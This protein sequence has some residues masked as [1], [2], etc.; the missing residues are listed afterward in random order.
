MLRNE[1]VD[2]ADIGNLPRADVSVEI[3]EVFQELFLGLALR[4]VV[5]VILEVPEMEVFF[6]PMHVPE[7]HHIAL[8]NEEYLQPR[9]DASGH[10]APR[11]P[12]Y[13]LIS[14][15]MSNF[16]IFRNAS[17]TRLDRAGSPISSSRTRG[18]TC[19]LTPN[20]SLSQPHWPS[21]PPSERL[22]QK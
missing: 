14:P 12:P 1:L 4:D 3:L 17:T 2:L 16:F 9:P 11:A 5:R 20:L 10:R 21:L 7:P 13:A 22:L 15:S 18:T 8:P 19:Q 6:L